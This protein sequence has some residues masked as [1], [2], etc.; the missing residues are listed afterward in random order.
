MALSASSTVACGEIDNT[1]CAFASR[2]PLTVFI[3][4]PWTGFKPTALPH[5]AHADQFIELRSEWEYPRPGAPPSEIAASRQ[6][7]RFKEALIKLV[8]T[9]A[10]T[11]AGSN[12]HHAAPSQLAYRCR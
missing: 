3:A 10:L 4:P 6:N 9:F 5:A 2:I 8:A 12:A 11:C 7:D 1:F